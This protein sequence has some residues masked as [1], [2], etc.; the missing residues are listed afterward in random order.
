MYAS[1]SLGL[2]KDHPLSQDVYNSLVT[3][4]I[5]WGAKVCGWDGMVTGISDTDI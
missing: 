2:V 5:S 4:L 3:A 1:W